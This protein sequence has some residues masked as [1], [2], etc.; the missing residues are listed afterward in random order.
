MNQQR[1]ISRRRFLIV[2][3]GA[4]A[5]SVL[6]GGSLATA[7]LQ[8]PAVEFRTLSCGEEIMMEKIL[9][10]YAS[11]CG[12]TGE[13]AAAISQALCRQGATVDVRR[14]Q[15]VRDLAGYGAV[16]LGSA[17]R[18]GKPLSE[19]VK[20]ARKHQ[21]V[22][23]GMPTAYFVACAAMK[24]DTPQSRAEASAYLDPLHKIVAPV[25]VGLFGGKVDHSKLSPLLR[26]ALSR[27]TS[28]QMAEGDWRDWQTID[29]WAVTLRPALLAA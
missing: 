17:V 3:G 9:V 22:L 24:E 23:E 5:A 26:F 27:D 8:Q 25:G 18:M 4:L 14:V 15:E 2:A 28:G 29:A 13:V 1:G 7:G 11:K 12:S 16:V 6:C 19:A 20:F 21:A 10:A